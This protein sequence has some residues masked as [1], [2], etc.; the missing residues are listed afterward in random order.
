MNDYEK[1]R[2]C[3]R[4]SERVT[5]GLSCFHCGRPQSYWTRRQKVVVWLVFGL[6]FATFARLIYSCC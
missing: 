3:G 5:L 6:I 4:R 1:C 2:H